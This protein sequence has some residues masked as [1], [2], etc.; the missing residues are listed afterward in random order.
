MKEP[1]EVNEF[2]QAI[3]KWFIYGFIA[4]FLF[5]CLGHVLHFF[6][7]PTFEERESYW[8]GKDP[9]KRVSDMILDYNTGKVTYQ[10]YGPANESDFDYPDTTGE[11]D[12]ETE[13]DLI[14]D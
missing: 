12:I 5:W 13:I 2:H 4:I 1:E 7:K 14:L 9:N 8:H 10:E 3:K 6:F 11:I